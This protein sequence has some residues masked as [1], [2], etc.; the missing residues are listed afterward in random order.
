MIWARGPGVRLEN[1]NQHP[2]HL[3]LDRTG[4]D[5]GVQTSSIGI[6][7]FVGPFCGGRVCLRLCEV[8]PLGSDHTD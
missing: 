2:G 8:Q 3:A 6:G 4:H 5:L 1:I 7:G